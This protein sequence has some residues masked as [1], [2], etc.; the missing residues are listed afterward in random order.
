MVCLQKM[1]FDVSVRLKLQ[2]FK[3]VTQ[4]RIRVEYL[5]DKYNYMTIFK[6]S[7]KQYLFQLEKKGK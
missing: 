7:Y 1:S 3:I 5:I 2:Q 4:T 6:Q